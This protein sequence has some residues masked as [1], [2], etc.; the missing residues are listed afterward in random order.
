MNWLDAPEAYL[1]E[2]ICACRE[3]RVIIHGERGLLPKVCQHNEREIMNSTLLITLVVIEP[4]YQRMVL[5]PGASFKVEIARWPTEFQ[6]ITFLG[7]RS[8][9]SWI[10]LADRGGL[11]TANRAC[12]FSSFQILQPN[13]NLAPWSILYWESWQAVGLNSTP[14]SQLLLAGDWNLRW[15]TRSD[16]PWRLST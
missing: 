1:G 12:P 5:A 13:K 4:L 11:Q 10:W 9:R 8:R 16:N 6:K 3:A 2:M 15:Q 7:N 14:P